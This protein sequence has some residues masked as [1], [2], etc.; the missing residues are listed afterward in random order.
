VVERIVEGRLR[1]YFEETVLFEQPFV[2]DEEVTAGQLLQQQ[3]AALG[4]AIT[5][6]RFVRYE[7]GE[8][9]D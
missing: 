5:L 8:D 9:L 4:E 1:K 6:A 3:A 2:K 7:L